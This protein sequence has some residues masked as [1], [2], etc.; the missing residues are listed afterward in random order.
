VLHP[1]DSRAARRL[2]D[3]RASQPGDPTLQNLIAVLTAKLELCSRLPIYEYEAGSQGYDG[4]ARAFRRLAEEERRTFDDLVDTLRQ[5]IDDTRPTSIA[6]G[7]R[8]A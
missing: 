5:H 2:N 3:L 6:R 1:D 7:G 8:G 4:S